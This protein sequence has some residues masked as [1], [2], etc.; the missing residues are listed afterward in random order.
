MSGTNVSSGVISTGVTVRP[1]QVL[2]V[3]SGG[4]AISTFVSA[5]GGLT[6]SGGGVAISTGVDMGGSE[7]VLA[8]GS[9]TDDFLNPAAIQI[10]SGTA[11]STTALF[12]AT[13]SVYGVVSVASFDRGEQIVEAGGTAVATTISGVILGPGARNG[14]ELVLS[15]GSA[16]GTFLI[17]ALEQ[18]SSGGVAIATSATG[19]SEF[20]ISAGGTAIDAVI[21][22]VSF[23]SIS[24][25]GSA[26]GTTLSSGG[27]ELD[28]GTTVSAVV[29][30]GGVLSVTG[31]ATDPG[32]ASSTTIAG[33]TAIF[34]AY[35]AASA[36]ITFS[37]S[38]GV[39][40]ISGGTVATAISNVAAGN[41]IDLATLAYVP[42]ASLGLDSTTDLLTVTAGGSSVAL[43][44]SGDYSVSDFAVLADSGSG[45]LVSAV[46]A[47]CFALGT[48]IATARG[49]VAVEQLAVG[50]RVT[51]PEGET[52]PITWIGSRRVDC[53]RQPEPEKVWPVRVAAHA[54]GP[55]AP[56]RDLLL[57]PDHA[58]FAEGVLIPVKHLING[59]S[60][61]QVVIPAVT[62]F[63]VALDDHAVILAE[64]LAVESYLDTGDRQAFENTEGATVLHPAF[65]SER[66]DITLMMDAVGYAPLRITGPEVDAVK[67]RLNV[68][69]RRYAS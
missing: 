1:G 35:G 11:T 56:S 5:G 48:R 4:T 38:G 44:L 34:G 20:D 42:S 19:L 9:T 22:S 36:G 45:T 24:F 39:L 52:R 25:G 29:S 54:F 37:G 64:G 46:S 15:G 68:D 65:A 28:A 50:D 3:L 41:E 8:G 62:Y 14:S 57:S 30:G 2:N 69:R 67:A 21:G 53:R 31:T 6:V 26:S 23:D 58:V 60:V 63:H 18:V 7:T 33:G 17:S 51:T 27:S 55:G 49:A 59:A 16:S 61:R 32:V 12:N 43:Q 47:P 40:A 66:G 13:Q 10:V